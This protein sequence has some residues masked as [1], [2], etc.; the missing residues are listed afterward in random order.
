MIITLNKSSS[1]CESLNLEVQILPAHHWKYCLLF[2]FGFFKKLYGVVENVCRQKMRRSKHLKLG[3]IHLSLGNF[4]IPNIEWLVYF[5]IYH[6]LFYIS[7]AILLHLYLFKLL[8]MS[9]IFKNKC[10]IRYGYMLYT[11][12][13]L[14][15]YA[16]IFFPTEKLRMKESKHF[17][18]LVKKYRGRVVLQSMPQLSLDVGTIL[19]LHWIISYENCWTG[20][21]LTFWWYSCLLPKRKK[22]GGGGMGV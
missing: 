20:D 9:R 6:D 11:T 3:H 7:F 1:K 17:Y 21:Y 22:K 8:S 15:Y 14:L 5:S 4:R 18:D 2:P 12:Y 10:V 19:I 16:G 13:Y